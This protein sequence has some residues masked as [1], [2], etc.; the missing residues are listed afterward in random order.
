[1]KKIWKKIFVLFPVMFEFK[2]IH[3]GPGILALGV[4]VG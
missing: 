1:M 3:Y 2:N 4:V